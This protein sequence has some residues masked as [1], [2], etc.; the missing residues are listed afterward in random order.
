MLQN[1]S[2]LIVVLTMLFLGKLENAFG[3]KTMQ[4]KRRYQFLK[5]PNEL[6]ASEILVVKAPRKQQQNLQQDPMLLRSQGL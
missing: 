1:L 3:L 2:I 5:L 4:L 6:I